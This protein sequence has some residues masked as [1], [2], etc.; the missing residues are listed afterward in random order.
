MSALPSA[1]RLTCC[2]SW[3]LLIC[4]LCLV[5]GCTCR[6]TRPDRL[7]RQLPADDDVRV[8]NYDDD[9]VDED[10]QDNATGE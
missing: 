10:Y 4:L 5:S 3:L 2:R 6:G 9:D 8:S 1:L 7:T